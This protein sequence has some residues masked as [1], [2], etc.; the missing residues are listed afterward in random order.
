[1]DCISTNSET[2]ALILENN[3]IK[4]HQPRYNI[5]LKDSKR[6]AYLR[7]SEEEYPRLLLSR[8]RETGPKVFGP[9]TSAAT[10]DNLKTT[11]T[12][13][14]KIRTCKRLPKKACLRY[15]INLCSAPC[16][17]AISDS[18]YLNDIRQAS[19]VL[20]GRSKDIIDE[21]AVQMRKASSSQNF[22]RALIL[23]DRMNSL[24]YM[25]EK[26]LMERNRT[27]DQDIINYQV[28]EGKTY[29]LVF[30]CSKGI[31]SGKNEFVFDTDGPVLE[32][33]IVQYFSDQDIPKEIIIPEELDPAIANYLSEI[34]NKVVR[35]TRP[36]MGEK[37]KLLDLVK[38]NITTTFFAPTEKIE[39]L[40]SVLK[41]EHPP[42]VI[43]CFDISHLSGTSTVASMVRFE[44]GRP[45]KSEYRR[46][47]IRS[48]EG[49]DDFSSMKEVVH[50]RYRRLLSEDAELPDLIIVD[51]G[52]GQLSSA[53]EALEDLSVKVPLIG[54]AK[55]LEE[56]VLP[57]TS[58]LLD[59]KDKALHLLQ[60]IRDEA[61]R[62]AITYNRNLRKID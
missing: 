58:I 15:H 27:F 61:H 17:G 29:L 3:L 5:N 38:E 55:R 49:I 4:K 39:A 2:E 26:Q 18:D 19:A 33:F 46:F 23:R 45:A 35:I 40:Q 25:Y 10:R 52:K 41:L 43:E 24:K 54:L 14:F 34:G 7:F 12:R 20:Q 13:M 56:I 36:K 57:K 6:Y 22:E 30:H 50:R 37:K 47:R 28:R 60:Q 62:F 51:G 32:E 44:H 8:M 16:I 59:K 42:Q 31:L 9:F 48:V 53:M 1:M 11:V 21:L